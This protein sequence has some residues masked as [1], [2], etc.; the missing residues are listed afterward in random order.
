MQAGWLAEKP[1]RVPLFLSV[2]GQRGGPDSPHLTSSA[3]PG[4]IQIAHA[5]QVKC[6]PKQ[7]HTLVAPKPWKQRQVGYK[8]K[9]KQV[10]LNST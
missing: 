5:M 1:N 7:T 10:D 3:P 8:E 9:T 6:I 4:Q 2:K